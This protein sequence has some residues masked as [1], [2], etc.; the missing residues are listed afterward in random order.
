MTDDHVLYAYRLRVLASAGELGSV[1]AT[2]RIEL[3]NGPASL[4][5]RLNGG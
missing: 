4:H 1:A 3:L 2:L 5:R